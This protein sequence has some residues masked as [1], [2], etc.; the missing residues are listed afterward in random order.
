MVATIPIPETEQVAV[1]ITP[2]APLSVRASVLILLLICTP[3]K[4]VAVVSGLLGNWYAMPASI[5][6][7]VVLCL[8]AGLYLGL[9]LK[10]R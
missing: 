3:I 6:M 7:C 4:A 5:T 8:A 1:V 2:C 9:N 10:R